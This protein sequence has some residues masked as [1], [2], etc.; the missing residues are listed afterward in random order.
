MR[1]HPKPH[2]SIDQSRQM[3][4]AQLTPYIARLRQEL[5]W[6]A[7]GPVHKVRSQQLEVG[8]KVRRLCLRG[9]APL[10]R[11]AMRLFNVVSTAFVASLAFASDVIPSFA[12]GSIWMLTPK[13]T[14]TLVGNSRS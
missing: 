1:R 11:D 9:R 7:G 5:K 12:Q 8:L 6:R 10:N 14:Q 4:A 2:P 13:A 3:T